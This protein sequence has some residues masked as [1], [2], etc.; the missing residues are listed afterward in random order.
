MNKHFDGE[1]FVKRLLKVT[2]ARSQRAMAE[3]LNEIIVM[4]DAKDSKI[5]KWKKNKLLPDTEE[6]Y[7]IADRYNC[8]VDY[9]L[10]LSDTFVTKQGAPLYTARDVCRMLTE[11]D[12]QYHLI[13]DFEKEPLTDEDVE[14]L[15]P[16]PEKG[17][18]DFL[19]KFTRKRMVISFTSHVEKTYGEEQDTLN[20]ACLHINNFLDWYKH[21]KESPQFS[22]KDE[23][24]I[25]TKI[26]ELLRHVPNELPPC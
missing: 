1:Q 16:S 26:E 24:Y 12:E 2:G 22:E 3:Q 15:I 4:G 11:I 13:F 19:K 10:G 14:L 8:S 6:L 5:S 20:T 18:I 25:K 9:L 7:L 21:Y 17:Q 23:L